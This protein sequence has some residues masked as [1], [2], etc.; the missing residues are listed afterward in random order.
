MA[1]DPVG[2]L[3]ELREQ[4]AQV[5][6]NE[7]R[8]R[9]AAIYAEQDPLL[10]GQRRAQHPR[11]AEV[12]LTQAR[13]GAARGI[14]D[15]DEVARCEQTLKDLQAEI[16][17]LIAQQRAAVQAHRK[18]EREI[19]DLY[20]EHFDTF[21]AIAEEKAVAAEQAGA[22]LWPALAAYVTAWEE[23]YGAWLEPCRANELDGAPVCPLPA[24]AAIRAQTP[25]PP[26]VEREPLGKILTYRTNDGR[27][28]SAHEGST[29]HDTLE[30]DP[31]WE[32]VETRRATRREMHRAVSNARRVSRALTR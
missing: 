6:D 12:E 11:K 26:V 9:L 5:S 2:R 30:Q 16:T 10:P 14:V 4:L 13:V 20:G 18:I 24:P 29:Q 27:S 1:V 23:A 15:V 21:A 28:L 19:A 8:A 7:A 3:A 22:A 25:R 32:L 31:V 17:A